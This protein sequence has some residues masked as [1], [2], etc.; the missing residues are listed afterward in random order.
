MLCVR[1][2][3]SPALES[4]AVARRL[5]S[6]STGRVT[7]L[8]SVVIAKSTMPMSNREGKLS[9][10]RMPASSTHCTHEEANCTTGTSAL[11]SCSGP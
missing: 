2:V 9:T 7:K 6:I 10:S 11:R 8:K 1:T 5:A 3:V 4:H